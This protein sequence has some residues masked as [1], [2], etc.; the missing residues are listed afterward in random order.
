MSKGLQQMSHSPCSQRTHRS[1]FLS[2]AEYPEVFPLW[3]QVLADSLHQ[4]IVAP[5]KTRLVFACECSVHCTHTQPTK[6]LGIDAAGAMNNKCSTRMVNEFQLFPVGFHTVAQVRWNIDALIAVNCVCNTIFVEN[7]IVRCWRDDE[8]CTK[9]AIRVWKISIDDASGANTLFVPFSAAHISFCFSN[10]ECCWCGDAL[11]EEL[12]SRIFGIH[13]IDTGSMVRMNKFGEKK[14]RRR[15]RRS[16]NSKTG[17][18]QIS[19]AAACV[20]KTAKASSLCVYLYLDLPPRK[21]SNS[22]E[23]RKCD[24]RRDS[25]HNANNEH[26]SSS[27]SS[28]F[29]AQ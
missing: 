17:L 27:A 12:P 3:W 20:D 10:Y 1:L 11:F 14:T 7:A 16:P 29:T 19:C 22:M 26:A 5:L 13:S 15:R 23:I 18:I 21:S 24:A 6:Q 8:T 28:T 9:N 2:L 4:R 25:R